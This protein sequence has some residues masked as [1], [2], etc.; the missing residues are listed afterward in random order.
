MQEVKAITRVI[1]E[2]ELKCNNCN[3]NVMLGTTKI[4]SL[5]KA[6]RRHTEKTGHSVSVIYP[7]VFTTI[8]VEK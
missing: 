5:K 7:K 1:D 3:F 4:N 8:K 6:A 2:A